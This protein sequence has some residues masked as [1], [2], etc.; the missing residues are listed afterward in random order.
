MCVTI[1]VCSMYSWAT[2]KS[3]AFLP[4]DA[5]AQSRVNVYV[6][7]LHLLPCPFSTI[8]VFEGFSLKCCAWNESL[9]Q[10][11]SQPVHLQHPSHNRITISIAFLFGMQT[12]TTSK[13]LKI[14]LLQALFFSH[15][16]YKSVRKKTPPKNYCFCY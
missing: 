9:A 14:T 2:R 7:P 12:Y 3:V 11:F 16:R 8:H 6:F 5:A 1:N 13:T 4:S 15:F 10:Q